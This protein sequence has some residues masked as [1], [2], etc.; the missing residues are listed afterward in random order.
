MLLIIAP[1]RGTDD[2]GSGHF[3]APRGSRSHRGIDYF[4]APG[5]K[6]CSMSDGIVTKLGY[7]YAHALQYRY[8]EVSD[9][10]GYKHRYFY[11]KPT[12]RVNDRISRT[13][14][15]GIAQNISEYYDTGTK[16]MKPHVH[17]EILKGTTPIDPE[18][19]HE[20]V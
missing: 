18:K 16:K 2:F 8:V 7:P 12:V 9:A 1:P 5:S 6:V 13:D 4:T 3:G 14:V 11:V 10:G 20:L 17:Y 15:L 19:F